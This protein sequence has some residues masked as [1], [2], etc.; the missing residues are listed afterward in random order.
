[1]ITS[2]ILGLLGLATGFYLCMR[3]HDHMMMYISS[4]HLLNYRRLLLE[5]EK[6]DKH[7]EYH[8]DPSD[9]ISEFFHRRSDYPR[10]SSTILRMEGSLNNWVVQPMVHKIMHAPPT[11][12]Q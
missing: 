8:H 1:M 6:V 2:L 9:I 11:L 10:D 5:T 7:D 3:L 12:T 4:L